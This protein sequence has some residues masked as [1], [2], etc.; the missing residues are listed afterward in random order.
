MLSDPNYAKVP[1][2]LLLLGDEI[3]LPVL[4]TIGK[5]LGI[6]IFGVGFSRKNDEK[7]R[8]N[9]SS[10]WDIPILH[11]S[12][13]TGSNQ[14]ILEF[15]RENAINLVIMYSFDVI[16]SKEI[17][18]LPNLQ[19]LNV[20]AGKIPDYRGANVLNWAIINGEKE[21][22]VTV[23]EAKIPVDTGPII[24]EWVIAIDRDDTALSAREKVGKS[25]HQNLSKILHDFLCGFIIPKYQTDLSIQPYKKRKA[26]DG[27][28]DWS[29][30]D[31]SIYNLVR[32]LVHP[33]PGARYID[34]N[35]N[36]VV[37]KEYLSLEEIKLI[38]KLENY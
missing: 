37:L 5:S 35:G 17:I 18:E 34:K 27:L 26:D 23:H 29:Y 38:R 6:E 32:G 13:N 30:S 28:F 1:K 11:S 14:L 19:I 22:G 10:A 8:L 2:R 12:S 16:L 31:E 15:V 36:L 21:I 20:H 3:G 24:G 25:V 4:Y 9:V 7:T 33:W